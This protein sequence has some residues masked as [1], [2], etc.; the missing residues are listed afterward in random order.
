MEI[1]SMAATKPSKPKYRVGQ[2]VVLTRAG[3]P[4]YLGVIGTPLKILDVI[5]GRKRD[6]YSHRYEVE[7][8]KGAEFYVY[9]VDISDQAP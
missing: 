5:K 3:Y 9:E 2:A 8:N 7:S 4:S 6:G 1:K